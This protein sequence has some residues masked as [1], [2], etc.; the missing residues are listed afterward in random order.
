MLHH[1]ELLNLRF[2]A[3]ALQVRVK[4]V[5]LRRSAAAGKLNTDWGELKPTLPGPWGGPNL[6]SSGTMEAIY[7]NNYTLSKESLGILECHV[8]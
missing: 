2:L 6:H 5:I 7:Y 1:S 3:C 4:H 8:E